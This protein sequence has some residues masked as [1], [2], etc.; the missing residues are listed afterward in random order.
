MMT[1]VL[2]I[3][4]LFLVVGPFS[5]RAAAPAVAETSAALLR[6][7]TGEWLYTKSADTPRHPASTTKILTTLVAIE[8]GNLDRTVAVAAADTKVEPSSV[9]LRAG[10]RV[11][12]RALL[13]AVMLRSANDAA[14]AIARAVGGSVPKFALR[15][16]KRAVAAGATKTRFANPH[17]LTNARHLTTARDL[18]LITRAAMANPTFRQITATRTYTWRYGAKPQVLENHN[19]MLK[20][21]AG[22]VGGKTGYTAAASKTLVVVA[23][24]GG[25]ELIAVL[26]GGH[27][28][29]IWQD[30]AAL[31]DHGFRMAQRK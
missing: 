12:L 21:Y 25:V 1:T 7:D 13:Y 26:L 5:L 23:R 11:S 22:C 15:M 14:M 10:Q 9:G 24:R 2:R 19:R 3:A 30:A 4:F 27:G 18:A 8:S 20:T 6:G 31:L 16:N 29:R 17:G 28:D